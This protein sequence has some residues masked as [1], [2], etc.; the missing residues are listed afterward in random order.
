MEGIGKHDRARDRQAKPHR[1]LTKPGKCLN[2]TLAG[3]SGFGDPSS[4]LG[5]LSA[6]HAGQF[7]ST[8]P[9]V[10]HESIGACLQCS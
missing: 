5:K 6:I 1:P 7:Y 8:R 3:Q 2:L 10:M 9:C 4:E